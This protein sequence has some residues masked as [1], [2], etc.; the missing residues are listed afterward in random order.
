MIEALNGARL[1][2]READAKIGLEEKIQCEGRGERTKII[3]NDRRSLSACCGEEF[4][5]SGVARRS[6]E[7]PWRA[8]ELK[9][10]DT[11]DSFES[12]V[13]LPRPEERT[14]EL[15]ERLNPK[16]GVEVRTRRIEIDDE[17]LFWAKMSEATGEV[18]G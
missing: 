8:A 6:S 10:R 15:K 17:D 11:R 18:C 3:N 7:R 16:I 13:E 9:P 4:R 5:A 12:R 1:W 2:E 14:G